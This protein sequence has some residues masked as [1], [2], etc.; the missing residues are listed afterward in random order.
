MRKSGVIVHIDS[1]EIPMSDCFCYLGSITHHDVIRRR[2]FIELKRDGLE[3]K[4]LSIC[5]HTIP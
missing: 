3:K 4:I 2:M 5:D 1:Q